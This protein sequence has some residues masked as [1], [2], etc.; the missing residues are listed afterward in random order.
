MLRDLVQGMAENVEPGGR[1]AVVGRL[2]RVGPPRRVEMTESKVLIWTGRP[3]ASQW[4]K[5]AVSQSAYS[6]SA[7]GQRAGAPTWRAAAGIGG[8]VPSKF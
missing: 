1:G 3:S 5:M 7:S 2:E 4:S 6:A 8:P